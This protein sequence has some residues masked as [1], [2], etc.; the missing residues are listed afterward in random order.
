MCQARSNFSVVWNGAVPD[1]SILRRRSRGEFEVVALRCNNEECGVLIGGMRR[2]DQVLDYW[3]KYITDKTIEDVPPHIARAAEEAHLD[4]GTGAYRSAAVL[5]RA[6]V[7]ATAKEKGITSGTLSKKIDDMH[8]QGW[9][10]AHI[11]EAAHEVRH[12]G[13]DMAHGDFVDPVT[14][15]EAEEVLTLMDEVLAEIFQSPAVWRGSM[16][17][18][19]R[20]RR[21]VRRDRDGSRLRERTHRE[22]VQRKALI[23]PPHELFAVALR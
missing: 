12:L 17:R 10:R 3:P 8:S 5:A 23:A 20:R 2:L 21:V 18:G 19:W 15:E 11:K 14:Q 9:I 1:A 6:V 13:N 4:L 16:Q 7:E 22:D